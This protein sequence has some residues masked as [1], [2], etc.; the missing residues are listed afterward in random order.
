MK[1]CRFEQIKKCL[2]IFTFSLFNLTACN[3]SPLKQLPEVP[4]QG[5]AANTASELVYYN[6]THLKLVKERIN[7]GDAY[8]LEKYKEV[9][10]AGN[11]ALSFQ[12]DPVTNKTQIPP[13]KDMHDYLTYAP[14]RWPDPAK[15]DGLPWIARDGIIN[16]VARGADT[17][18]IRKAEFFHAVEKLSWSYYFSN[19]RQYAE[20]AI[21]LIKVWYLNPETKVNPN[22]NFGQGVPGI[23]DGRKAGVH[24]W[25]DQSHIITALQIFEARGVLPITVKTGMYTWLNEYLTWLTT[26][27]MAIDAGF[28]RQNHANHYSFQVIGLMLYLGKNEQAKALIEE[29]KQTRIADQ[30]LPNGAQPREMGRTKSVHYATLNLWSMTEIALMGQKVGIDLWDYKTNDGRSLQQAYR[31]L[32]PYVLSPETWP[33]RQITQ[34]GAVKAIDHYMQRLFSKASTAMGV[35]YID[36]KV[37]LYLNLSA[38]EALQYPPI[39]MLPAIR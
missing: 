19:N 35:D 25:G 33:E 22:I 37:K 7:K 30:I 39:N 29:A 2:V 34:G 18:F 38:L 8:F 20:K 4:V 23:T 3:S 13:S 28:T 11:E 17:D 27:P 21:E 26:N 24:E 15:P 6:E 36:P 14:Y 12:V 5:S 31:Y 10:T 16:P 32:A 1:Y 9:I